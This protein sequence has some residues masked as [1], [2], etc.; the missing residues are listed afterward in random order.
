MKFEYRKKYKDELKL[1]ER[2][3][4]QMSALHLISMFMD[5]SSNTL[6]D[7]PKINPRW[8]ESHKYKDFQIHHIEELKKD[9]VWDNGRI[10]IR[11]T[12]K[13]YV[14]EMK[15]NWRGK[16]IKT[17]PIICVRCKK[18]KKL[19]WHCFCEKCTREVGGSKGIMKFWRNL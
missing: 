17:T 7:I 9:G 13:G 10:K 6:E 12:K 19:N 14:L 5:T 3:L 8:I 16:G 11:Q 1:S 15:F 4:E 18:V 2:Q